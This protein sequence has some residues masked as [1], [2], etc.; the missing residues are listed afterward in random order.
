MTKPGGYWKLTL[1]ANWNLLGKLG[2]E[3]HL[4]ACAT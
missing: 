4:A 1:M 2:L 3:V